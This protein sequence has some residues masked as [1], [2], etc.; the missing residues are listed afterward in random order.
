MRG[1]VDEVHFLSQRMQLLQCTPCQDN[2]HV[3]DGHL[4][5]ECTHQVLSTAVSCAVSAAAL[6]PLPRPVLLLPPLQQVRLLT[7]LLMLLVA[8]SSDAAA[9]VCCC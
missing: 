2:L 5:R 4:T 8:N 9:L 3:A 1:R 7:F 6:Q